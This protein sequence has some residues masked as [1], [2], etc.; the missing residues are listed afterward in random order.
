MGGVMGQLGSVDM[1]SVVVLTLVT[2]QRLAE[3]VYAR[4]N[5]ARLRARGAIEYDAGH[6]PLIVG[7]HAAWLAGLWLGAAHLRPDALWLAVFVVLQGL[8]LWV[9][10]TLGPR[11]TTR[12]LV[13]PGA[14]L[15]L[16]G[17]YRILSHP[18]YAVVAA[19]IFVLPMAYGLLLYAL[20][21][22]VLDAAILSIR[23]RAENRALGRSRERSN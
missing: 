4:R 14:P 11:W 22:S 8:R 21:F 23:I 3:L 2:V 5:E 1:V 9:L 17:P 15:V 10:A 19:E 12:I 7:L 6:Y 16:G 18:N 20:V 13:L